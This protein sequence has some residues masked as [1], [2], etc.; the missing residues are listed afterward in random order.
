M[1]NQC[2]IWYTDYFQH[3]LCCKIIKSEIHLKLKARSEIS[4]VWREYKN[5]SNRY[6]HGTT[7]PCD[8]CRKFHSAGPFYT[9]PTYTRETYTVLAQSS[10]SNVG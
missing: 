7:V 3:D 5:H 4:N 9:V 6:I 2:N 1:V 10:Y 8:I